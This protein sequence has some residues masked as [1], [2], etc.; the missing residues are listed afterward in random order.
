MDGLDIYMYSTYRAA[1]DR[2]MWAG[3]QLVRAAVDTKMRRAMHELI[4]TR[5]RF[6][7]ETNRQVTLTFCSLHP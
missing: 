1:Q 5:T 3:Q 2:E 7:L 6:R 4:E